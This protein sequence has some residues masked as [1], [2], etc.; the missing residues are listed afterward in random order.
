MTKYEAKMLIHDSKNKTARALLG[1]IATSLNIREVSDT[2]REILKYEEAG[3]ITNDEAEALRLLI[4]GIIVDFDF[5]NG[6]KRTTPISKPSSLVDV[7]MN[8]ISSSNELTNV[9]SF[10]NVV[11]DM[12]MIDV[13]SL[14]EY[15]ELNNGIDSYIQSAIFNV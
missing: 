2:L 6:E 9:I 10:R 14:D 7:F 8:R 4:N 15:I 11:T 1:H 5:S 13:I 12:L 3:E